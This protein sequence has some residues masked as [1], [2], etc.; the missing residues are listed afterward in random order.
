MK[1]KNKKQIEMIKKLRELREFKGR[2]TELITVYIPAGYDVNSVQRQLEAEKSTAK[3]IKSTATRKNVTDALE[4][5]VRHLKNIKKTPDKGLALF[6][7]NIAKI[8]GQQDLKLWEIIPPMPLKVRI[9]RCDKEFVLEALESM[10]EAHRNSEVVSENPINK[11]DGAKATKIARDYLE[12]NYGNVGM[13]YY[14]VEDVTRN[15]DKTQFYIIC[16]LLE[17]F[18]SDERLYYKIKVNIEDGAILEVWKSKQ[19]EDEENEILLT[20]VKFKENNKDNINKANDKI[21]IFKTKEEVLSTMGRGDVEIATDVLKNPDFMEAGNK[22]VLGFIAQS[23]GDYKIIEVKAVK[24]NPQAFIEF[25][26]G[27]R[28][29]EKDNK[30]QT[31]FGKVTKVKKFE[32]KFEL[33]REVQ[34]MLLNNDYSIDSVKIIGDFM[35]KNIEIE[36]RRYCK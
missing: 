3:N 36:K 17:S 12:Q 6:C 19:V 18:G 31:N 1:I 11:I 8:E 20:R 21:A 33:I 2:Q 24:N 26:F 29:V 27:K 9:Y 22:E 14:R 30:K 16:S 15:E 28:I 25:A 4:K 5:I 35:K 32:N 10:L 13:L 23:G 7:G 34:R